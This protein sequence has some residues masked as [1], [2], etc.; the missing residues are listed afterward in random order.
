MNELNLFGQFMNLVHP[1]KLQ[2]SAEMYFPYLMQSVTGLQIP[3]SKALPDSGEVK[4]A[5]P[6]SK[7]ENF[8]ISQIIHILRRRFLLR[9][10]D[11]SWRHSPTL[12][13]NFFAKHQNP[14]FMDGP[15]ET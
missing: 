10:P 8:R 7:I 4:L 6:D 1:R 2:R 13:W 5:A 9:V 14:L 11:T 12:K 3:D 15:L